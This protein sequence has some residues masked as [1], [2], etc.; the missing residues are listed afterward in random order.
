MIRFSILDNNKRIYGLDILRTFAILSVIYEHG[1]RLLNPSII[2]WNQYDFFVFDGVSIFFVLSGYLIGQILIKLFQRDVSRKDIYNFWIRRWCR[3]LPAYFLVLSILGAWFYCINAISIKNLI[4]YYLFSQN[5][6]YPISWFFP[7]SWSLSIEEWFYL[8]VPVLIYFFIRFCSLKDKK[9]ILVTAFALILLT[10]GYRIYYSYTHHEASFV[11]WDHYYRK[12]VV[13]R[14]DS[15]MYGVLA[16]YIFVY[17]KEW[18][19]KNRK[20]MFVIGAAILIC[21]KHFLG[22]TTNLFYN[23]V[24]SFS[25]NSIGTVLLIP[26]LVAIERGEGIIYRMITFISIISYSMYLINLILVQNLLL[27]FTFTLTGMDINAPSFW[28]IKYLLYVFYSIFGSYLLFVF[29]ERP[30]TALRDKLMIKDAKY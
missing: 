14:L 2:S 18:W 24:L 23:N 4:P 17:Y 12:Q 20:I 10:T 25:I 5:L 19:T 30:T 8:I 1:Y 6:F 3:T 15:L 9:A 13:T 28:G 27:P 11:F 21:S 7:E 22:F 16:A 26:L 29:W